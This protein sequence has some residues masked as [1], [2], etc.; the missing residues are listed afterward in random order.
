MDL[1][2]D[3]SKEHFFSLKWKVVALLS[4][5]LLIVNAGLASLGYYE[6]RQLFETYQ[7]QIRES[8]ERQVKA[9]LEKSFYR[10]EQI[11]LMIPSLAKAAMPS[12]EASHCR[13][14]SMTR[15]L[16]ACSELR[17]FSTTS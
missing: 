9:L 11:T 3:D 10:L 12:P 15:L 16:L 2:D 17:N 7:Q 5:I 1:H 14:R 6:Q 8:Q 13:K 4:M